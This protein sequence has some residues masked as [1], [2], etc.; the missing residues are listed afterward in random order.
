MES[1]QGVDGLRYLNELA[2]ELSALLEGLGIVACPMGVLPECQRCAED[3]CFGTTNALEGVAFLY[4]KWGG[5]ESATASNETRNA[6]QIHVEYN[7]S[8]VPVPDQL[9]ELEP[10]LA[11]RC[12]AYKITGDASLF[13]CDICNGTLLYR[14]N[15]DKECMHN[16]AVTNCR[17]V[18]HRDCATRHI[19][20][21]KSALC[22]ACG[23]KIQA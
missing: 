8:T 12:V 18:F 11:A 16:M 19:E 14:K 2:Q 23:T 4:L 5:C 15:T 6:P 7:A 9:L 3:A 20:K 17:H 10:F 21:T 22:P 1:I 13:C